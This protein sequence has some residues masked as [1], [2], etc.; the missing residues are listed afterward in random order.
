M[1]NYTKPSSP[2][3]PMPLEKTVYPCHEWIHQPA[4][5]P[6]MPCMD[7]LSIVDESIKV[8]GNPCNNYI[9]R[10]SHPVSLGIGVA[11]SSKT[12]F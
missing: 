2:D 9:A 8:P 4:N 1:T 5:C 12:F 6:F 7:K 11:P 3:E 10:A